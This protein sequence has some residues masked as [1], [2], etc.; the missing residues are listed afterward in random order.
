MLFFFHNRLEPELNLTLETVLADQFTDEVFM[1]WRNAPAVICGRHQDMAVE[2][3]RERALS[4]GVP[5]V[6][7]S[8]G[9][10]TVYHDLGTVNFT[11]IVP[12]GHHIDMEQLCFPLAEVLRQWVPRLEISGNDLVI[13]GRKIGGTAQRQFRGR[14]LFHGCLLYRTDLVR[15]AE[16]LT[17]PAEKLQRHGVA[18]VRARVANLSEFYE[19]APPVEQ[20]LADLRLA[21]GTL[22]RVQAA[23]IPSELWEQA[24]AQYGREAS[25]V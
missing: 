2:V 5:V 1:F 18:S 13:D 9:G 7:R 6:R 19:T 14:R 23:E 16:L 11:H 10:G 8:T 24:E 22:L 25:Y 3:N 12:A 15:L 4:Y 21:C 17:P 20:F